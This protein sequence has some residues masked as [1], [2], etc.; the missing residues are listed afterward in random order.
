MLRT[1]AFLFLMV[2]SF[3]V[4]APDAR[5]QDSNAEANKLFVEAVTLYRQSQSATGSAK[6]EAYTKVR[7]LFDKILNEHPDTRPAK[8]ITQGGSPGGVILADLPDAG[9]VRVQQASMPWYQVVVPKGTVGNGYTYGQFP[10]FGQKTHA[11]EDIGGGCGLEVRAAADG[12][13][14]RVVKKGDQD[15]NAVG[16][17]VV[18]DHSEHF[19]KQ[20]FTVYFHL[21]DAPEVVLGTITKGKRIGVTGN[22]GASKGCHLHF[23]VRHFQGIRELYHPEWRNIYG[24][25]NVAATEVFK[26]DWSDPKEWLVGNFTNHDE[27]KPS[28]SDQPRALQIAGQS[29]TVSQ[30]PISNDVVSTSW[31][32]RQI[33][34][35]TASGAPWRL[36][37]GQA[38]S[39]GTGAAVF[40]N[41]K[42]ETASGLWKRDDGGICQSY[43]GGSSWVCHSI[44]K[45]NASKNFIM[46]NKEGA[47]TS[48]ISV[49]DRK[50]SDSSVVSGS[51][52]Q[53]NSWS[54]R[55]EINS[56]MQK[57]RSLQPKSYKFCD[58]YYGPLD[59]STRMALFDSTVFDVTSYGYN[60][61]KLLRP[62]QYTSYPSY[63]LTRFDRFCWSGDGQ[64]PRMIRDDFYGMF[65]CES[66][67]NFFSWYSTKLYEIY[68]IR[69]DSS[70]MKA[71]DLPL[72]TE[73]D[74]K[75]PVEGT[76]CRLATS[77]QN[78]TSA[79]WTG[80]CV[81]GKLS[82]EGTI[83]WKASGVANYKSRIGEKWGIVFQNG[84]RHLRKDFSD[85][86]FVMG[87]CGQYAWKR[88]VVVIAPKGTDK[89]V[90]SS[91]HLARHLTDEAAKWLVGKCRA[92]GDPTILACGYG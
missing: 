25:G 5:A 50:P 75:I 81:D 26:R 62:K 46:Q 24:D 14:T 32:K 86:K 39:S 44:Y 61:I 42:N 10:S 45:C 13:V 49:D 38:Q 85:F 69:P 9:N 59:R 18:I 4:S 15:Y 83:T 91:G 70:Q 48:I 36:I 43:N 40:T 56:A 89:R 92:G 28:V 23:E 71:V 79:N 87:E 80:T 73:K 84:H 22:T 17:A 34:G 3:F 54:S 58:R 60:R 53:E 57:V 51:Q 2:F 8:V 77:S 68:N 37:L 66:K 1:F 20:T 47:F 63:G 21:Q 35:V 19:E 27:E 82:G 88:G 52:V 72:T 74:R 29:C 6:S 55:P 30:S 78:P 90:F 64:C 41:S 67:D 65:Y 11:G 76:N 16:N 7:E 33:K 12:K 31:T